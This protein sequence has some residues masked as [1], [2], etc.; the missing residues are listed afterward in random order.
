[1]NTKALKDEFLLSSYQEVRALDEQNPPKTWLVMHTFSG[2]LFVKKQLEEHARI[3]CQKRQE[4]KNTHVIPVEQVL[5]GEDGYYAI[6]PYISGRT[7][8]EVLSEHKRLNDEWAVYYCLQILDGLEAIHR[9]GIVHRDITPA[10]ILVSVDQVIKITDFGIS[11]VREEEKIKDTTILG[12]YGY[13]APEQFGFRQTDARSDLYAVGAI[14]YKM[15]F[16][17]LPNEGGYHARNDELGRIIQKAMRMDPNDRYQ[18][19]REMAKDLQVLYKKRQVNKND[20]RQ[21]DN[22]DSGNLHIPGFRTGKVWKKIV[23]SIGY[24]LM[25]ILPISYMV[26]IYNHEMYY[27]FRNFVACLLMFWLFPLLIVDVGYWT[28]RLPFVR[29]LPK[30]LRIVF[31]VILSFVVFLISLYVFKVVPQ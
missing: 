28:K 13:A 22:A 18:S 12:T 4:I 31:R 8:E 1:M 2:K 27:F 5:S 29:A 26:D 17:M 14:L 10:N 20:K 6:E 16:G 7:L 9:V 19:A 25:L 24:F 23:A 21:F 30:E 3:M 15:L 11:R